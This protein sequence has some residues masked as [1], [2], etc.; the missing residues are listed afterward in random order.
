[1]F[2]KSCSTELKESLCLLIN[3]SFSQG[4]FPTEWKR[5]NVVPVFK[6]KNIQ[7]VTNYR[8]I[9][10]LS[11]VS[12]I[13]EKCMYNYL[14]PL[15]FCKL[16]S[17]Q[18]GFLSGRSTTTQLV[19]YVDTLFKSLNNFSQTDIVYMD[20]AKA[21]DSV[22]HKMLIEK[23]KMYGFGG[24]ILKWFKSYL[25]N[26]TQRVVISGISS[27]WAPV[28]SGVPQGSILGPFLFLIFIDMPEVLKY[29]DICLFADDTKIFKSI[30]SVNDCL[31][32]Q[33]DIDALYKWS[34]KWGLNFNPSKC[35]IL[36]VTRLTNQ[37]LFKYKLNGCELER[38]TEMKDLGIIIDNKLSWNKHVTQ[39]VKKANNF[40]GLIK[41]TVEHKAHSFVKS[42]LFKTLVC[43]ILEYCTPARGGLT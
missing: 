6:S 23:L 28:Q 17:F 33:Q 25:E 41:R 24:N 27:T 42:Q 9:S 30:N 8:P 2:L 43:S 29:S 11:I 38:V 35:K 40:L 34:T 7:D 13:A 15:I 39:N 31:K 18:H 26:R 5:A 1:M 4:V 37:Y 36:T 20:F 21:F 10:L 19:Q 3:K 22:P 32:L 12:K 14:Y 16:S